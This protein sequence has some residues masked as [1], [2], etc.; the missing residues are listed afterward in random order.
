MIAN[1]SLIAVVTNT[2]SFSPLLA[3]YC[4]AEY[5]TSGLTLTEP[6]SP[7]LIFFLAFI[8]QYYEKDLENKI[9]F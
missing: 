2:V 9:I 7:F 1:L 4:F 8:K 3:Q 6:V 5:K